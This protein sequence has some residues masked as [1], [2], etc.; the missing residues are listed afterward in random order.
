[1]QYNDVI[2]ETGG[3]ETHQKKTFHYDQK[4]GGSLLKD[5]ALFDL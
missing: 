3:G 4:G 5:I 2:Y 1:M